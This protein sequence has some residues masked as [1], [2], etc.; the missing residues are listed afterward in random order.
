MS[1]PIH[2][3]ND[4][5]NPFRDPFLPKDLEEIL[6]S[7]D[8]IGANFSL[9][10]EEILASPFWQSVDYLGNPYKS[11][12]LNLA[13]EIDA[14]YDVNIEPSYHSRLH[15]K[16]VCLILSYL[17]MH[18]GLMD[19]NEISKNAWNSSREEKWVL[20][21]AAIAHDFGHPGLINRTPFEIEMKSVALLEAFLFKSKLNNN[22]IES[23]IHRINPW[24]LATDPR[25]YGALL[26]KITSAKA[27][28]ED[29]LA[30]LLIEADL[31][32]SILP[33]KGQMLG[34]RLAEEWKSVNPTKSTEVNS[35]QGRVTFLESLRFVSPHT[36]VLGAEEI[37]LSS[38]R[39]LT[40]LRY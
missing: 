29:C 33:V 30:M 2:T 1:K 27:S 40:D 24:I 21:F 17:L 11:L 6:E 36:Q 14:F 37:R 34:A 16:D 3:I 12:C 35:K 31:F 32:A 4:F 25:A 26:S 9:I 5:L 15:F 13:N 23:I 28:H 22:L 8:C 19:V 20:L 18:E 7:S 39:A 38:I 10:V